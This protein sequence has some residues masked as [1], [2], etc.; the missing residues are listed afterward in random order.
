MDPVGRQR[1]QGGVLESSRLMAQGSIHDG[2]QGVD[3]CA[4]EARAN[5]PLAARTRRE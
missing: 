3:W 5:P 1:A 2:A 4:R